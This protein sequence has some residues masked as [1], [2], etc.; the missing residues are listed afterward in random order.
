MI[1][2]E[3]NPALSAEIEVSTESPYDAAAIVPAL[4]ATAVFTLHRSSVRVG[5]GRVGLPPLNFSDDFYHRIH[6]IPSNVALGNMASA[7][8]RPVTL[9]NAYLDRSVTLDTAVLTDGEGLSATGPAS[10]PLEFLPL[11]EHIYNLAIS[12]QGPPLIAA[13]L[14][15][16]FDG[17]DPIAI[18][19]TG[20]RL[21]AW[22]VS[23]DWTQPIEE[24]LAWLTDVQR[25]LDGSPTR[26]PLRGAPRRSLEFGV[27]EGGSER[28]ILENL[29]F[30]WSA[31]TWALP[32]WMD[33]TLLPS[34]LTAADDRVSIDT[35][36]LDFAPGSL[37]MLWR[38]ADQY[39]LIEVESVA[40]NEV[41]FA[42]QLNRDWPAGT[43]LYPCRK[44]RMA[45]APALRRRNDRVVMARVRFEMDEP[46]DWPA[47]SPATLYR[48]YPVFDT[49]SDESDDP[50]ATFSRSLVVTDGDVGLVDVDDYSGLVFGRQSHAWVLEGRAAR[51]AHRSLLYWLQ[52]RARAVWVPTWTDDIE[53]AETV[54]GSGQVLVVV[55][56]G[57]ASALRQQAG[58]RHIRVELRDGSVFHREIRSSAEVGGREQLVMDAAFGRPVA[59]K[60]VVLMCWMA[61]CVQENDRIEIS[62][63][64]DINGVAKSRTAFIAE[65]G[66]EPW[67]S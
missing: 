64:T 58:R 30:D 24:V 45:E 49:R 31:R 36:G 19:I 16:A 37:A 52:G 2:G 29:I 63:L 5:I 62:H 14:T 13:T 66:E 39:D 8:S 20:T 50:S 56:A 57:I 67:A 34:P 7:Q 32:I 53:L 15:F 43:R 25:S 1:Y 60:D 61:L 9:W 10:L 33:I 6:V 21:N 44:A 27:V 12:D 4:P 55:R 17:F 41:V 51:T 48:G 65:P 35:T 28:R 40:S 38:S 22:P 42:R 47:I 11:Q 54:P 18:P 26:M 23:A 3:V 46:C 59:P